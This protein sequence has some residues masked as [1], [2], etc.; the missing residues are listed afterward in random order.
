MM[1]KDDLMPRIDTCMVLEYSNSNKK[2]LTICQQ[3]IQMGLYPTKEAFRTFRSCMEE[4][5][6]ENRSMFRRFD[7][8]SNR[9]GMVRLRQNS[10]F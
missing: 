1:T 4:L 6:N 2:G 5:A 3:L 7:G 9:G 8:Q 10:D